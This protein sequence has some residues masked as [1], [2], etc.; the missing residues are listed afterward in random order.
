M[1][2]TLCPRRCGAE[3]TEREGRGF[4]RMPATAVVARAALHPWEEP[5]LCGNRGAGTVFFSGCNLGCVY[6]Q[7]HAISRENFGRPVTTARLREIFLDLIAHKIRKHDR[8]HIVDR[9]EKN[10]ALQ[11]FL[12]TECLVQTKHANSI[13]LIKAGDHIEKFL[14]ITG[15]LQLPA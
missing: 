15:L 7:N 5:V 11:L 1:I 12:N 9:T 8:I 4:C 6:C 10:T 2:C 3:R 13:I 14:F